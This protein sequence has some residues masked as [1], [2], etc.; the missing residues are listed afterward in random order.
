MRVLGIGGGFGHDA[1]AALVDGH[2]I[3]AACEEER[4]T[5]Q[6]R[7]VRQVPERSIQACLD[8]AGAGLSDLDCIAL[9]WNP[10]LAPD[11]L[12]LAA[13]R[14]VLLAGDRLANERSL[15]PVVEV[16]HH[17]AHAA[18]GWYTSGYD[19]AAVLVVDGQ[20]EAVSTTIFAAGPDGLKEL[21]RFPVRDSLG[22]F[23]AA[24]T[25][26]I[27]FPPG[28]AGKTMGLAALGHTVYP[29]PEIDLCR[30]GYEV[31]MAGVSK[32]ERMVSWLR[33][34][35]REFGPPGALHYAIDRSSGLLSRPLDLPPHLRDAAASA[36]GALERAMVHLARLAL[37]LAGSSR[38]I[39]G[40]GV[41]LNCA[42]NGKLRLALPGVDL[43]VNGAAHDGGTA[44]GA[45]LAIASPDSTACP[46]RRR[47]SMFLGP[48]FDS[49]KAVDS[50]CR[51]G[52][53]VLA[54]G[55]GP[56]QTA[57]LIEEGRVGAW[58]KDRAEY[59]P[60]ALGARSIIARADDPTIASRVNRIKGREDWRPLGPAMGRR[61]ADQLLLGEDGLEAMVEARWI[62]ADVDGAEVRGVV[63]RDG[64][65]RPL[66]VP[67]RGHP[68]SDLVRTLGSERG[69]RAIINTSFN[70]EHE[71]LVNSPMDALRTFVTTDL[72]FL[73]LDNTLLVKPDAWARI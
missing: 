42:A 39:L 27:G 53:R 35:T 10:Y 37:E 52:V 38:L 43:F 34:L 51:S 29:F 26:Y 41:A 17:L 13:S 63:H 65:L 48:R 33:R 69:V 66:L 1:S 67:E 20:G 12:R 50:A 73:A 40:G 60:R 28:S 19:D 32:P 70:A 57:R 64:S 23:F 62:S 21:A 3:V 30:E 2:T 61:L 22:F 56:A 11:D 7:A 45:A 58:F 68:F 4:F 18:L 24:V 55:D 8:L 6:K 59:G 31:R 25:R 16:D 47:R 46:P 54:E 71:P 15:P 9:G 72:D 49:S 36:Q 44:L 14:D 5:R